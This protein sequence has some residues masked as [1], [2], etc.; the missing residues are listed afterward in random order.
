MT[1]K[2]PEPF[3]IEMTGSNYRW[4][5]RYPDSEGRFAEQNERTT[6]DIH[7]PDQTN[8]VLVLKSDDYVYTLELPQY[9]M[10][11]IAVPKLEF[12]MEF[13]T[14]EAG[15]FPLLGDELCGDPHPELKGDLIVEPREQFL[16][17]LKER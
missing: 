11:E 2:I 3:C 15:R 1:A 8:V 17:W 13:R 14:P 6:R 9:Q 4:H 5:V 12:R 7:V 10:K 16:K